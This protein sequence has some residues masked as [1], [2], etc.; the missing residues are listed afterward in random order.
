MLPIP[1][2]LAGQLD[3]TLY[4]LLNLSM[5]YEADRRIHRHSSGRDMPTIPEHVV[6]INSREDADAMQ[7]FRLSIAE[8]KTLR[9][10]LSIPNIFRSSAGDRCVLL[11]YHG[12]YITKI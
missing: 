11:I 6:D 5:L 8:M 3:D 1:E 4:D 10:A 2:I 12:Y 9:V 7:D